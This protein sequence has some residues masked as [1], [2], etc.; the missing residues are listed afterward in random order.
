MS[1]LLGGTAWLGQ[2]IAAEA[3][4]RDQEVTCLARGNSG[5]V[6]RGARFVRADRD[7][8]DAYDAVTAERWDAVVDVSRQPGHV[9]RAVV[10]GGPSGCAAPGRWSETA[11]RPRLRP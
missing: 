3:A 7:R 6:P 1:L 2:A 10:G 5:D 9:R 11:Q 4:A 8:A